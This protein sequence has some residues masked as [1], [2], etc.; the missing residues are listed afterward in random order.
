[1][2]YIILILLVVNDIFRKLIFRYR[3]RFYSVFSYFLKVVVV[4]STV[5]LKW[6]AHFAVY[7]LLLHHYR[8][9]LAN[10]SD[11]YSL[12]IGLYKYER[13]AKNNQKWRTSSTCTKFAH[14]WVVP[15]RKYMV[16]KYLISDRFDL[17][18]CFFSQFF[19]NSVW[20]FS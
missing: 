1:M 15:V 4:G 16:K 10:L 7:I 11:L 19:D 8:S 18:D 13:W 12:V 20:A 14:F 9:N 5:W 3:N 6:R 17:L 2:A